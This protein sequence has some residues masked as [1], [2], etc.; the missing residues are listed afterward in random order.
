MIVSVRMSHASVRRKLAGNSTRPWP[1]LRATPA[2]AG[3]PDGSLTTLTLDVSLPAR[4]SCCLP[5]CARGSKDGRIKYGDTVDEVHDSI[6]AEQRRQRDLERAGWKV[7]RVRWSD[8]TLIDEVVAQVLV[9]IHVK[10]G[11]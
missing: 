9:A 4:P 8:L 11:H 3:K 10:K 5:C 2:D 1:T 7:I 6:E